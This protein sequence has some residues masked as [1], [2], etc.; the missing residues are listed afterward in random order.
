M[1]QA[2]TRVD[3]AKLLTSS[4]SKKEAETIKLP[5][6]PLPSGFR[7]WRSKVRK[8][9]A[10]ASSRPQ[11][12]WAWVREVEDLNSNIETLDGVSMDFETLD[13][14]LC[15][16][17]D[18]ILKDNTPNSH[19][20]NLP[21]KNPRGSIPTPKNKNPHVGGGAHRKISGCPAIRMA[22]RRGP[23]LHLQVAGSMTCSSTCLSPVSP[24]ISPPDGYDRDRREQRGG[25]T[26]RV[27]RRHA[28]AAQLRRR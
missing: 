22:E 27:R 17:V 16:A 8:A 3:L 20:K 1:T 10:G 6:L 13:A 2:G 21:N 15:T 28:A 9:V 23:A 12:A 26:G 7:E 11:E 5:Q 19:N 4:N 24:P 25:R 18:S 14:K